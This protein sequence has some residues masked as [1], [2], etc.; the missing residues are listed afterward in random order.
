VLNETIVPMY[1]VFKI[2]RVF[3]CKEQDHVAEWS[4]IDMINSCQW[5]LYN[6]SVNFSYANNLV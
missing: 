5:H 6:K 4:W 3:L 2:G 1:N